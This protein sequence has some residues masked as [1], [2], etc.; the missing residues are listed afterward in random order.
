MIMLILTP[1]DRCI[2]TVHTVHD[3]SGRPYVMPD[4]DNM[5]V[6]MMIGLLIDGTMHDWHCLPFQIVAKHHPT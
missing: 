5:L 3:I 1:E 2:V 4:V 6:D